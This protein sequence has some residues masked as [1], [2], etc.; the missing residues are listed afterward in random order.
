MPSK[1]FGVTLA[2]YVTAAYV[3]IN[4]LLD[5]VPPVLSATSPIDVTTHGSASGIKEF[6]PSGLKE[7]SEC[8]GSI[9]VIAT[10]TGQDALRAGVGTQMKFKVVTP[11]RVTSTD[12]VIFNAIVESVENDSFG[13]EGKD[14]QKFKLK[15]TGVAPAS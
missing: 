13:L 1:T 8:S 3:P 12:D 11:S 15:P 9:L 2:V 6:E 7:W 14:T 10:D 5:I 4:G